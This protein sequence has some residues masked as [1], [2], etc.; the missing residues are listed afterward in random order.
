LNVGA[1]SALS[2]GGLNGHTHTPLTT[3]KLTKEEGVGKPAERA[4]QADA[5][6]VHVHWVVGVQRLKVLDVEGDAQLAAL[7]FVNVHVATVC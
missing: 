7:S 2:G 4:L 3:T 6:R 1:A 5:C